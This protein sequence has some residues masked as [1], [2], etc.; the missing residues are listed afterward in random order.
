M[1]SKLELETS[2]TYSDIYNR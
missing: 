2:S 1:V